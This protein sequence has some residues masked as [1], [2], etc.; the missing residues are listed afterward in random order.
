MLQKIKEKTGEVLKN[1][2]NK[3]KKVC[4]SVVSTIVCF[5]VLLF[6]IIRDNRESTTT[7]RTN[8]RACKDLCRR[9]AKDNRDITKE[10]ERA[11]QTIRAIRKKGS[12]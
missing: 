5:F 12:K 10:L 7:A 11:E 9:A 3:N 8:N 1:V 6:K 4:I 2:W